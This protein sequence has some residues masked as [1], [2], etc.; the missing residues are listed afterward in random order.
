MKKYSLA[1]SGQAEEM[2]EIMKT[3]QKNIIMS[4]YL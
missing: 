3:A 2:F 1:T 4:N